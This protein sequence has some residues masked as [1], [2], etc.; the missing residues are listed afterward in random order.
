MLVPAITPVA[1]MAAPYLIALLSQ[2]PRPKGMTKKLLLRQ[3][4]RSVVSKLARRATIGI[5]IYG[6]YAA[7]RAVA[8][9]G[10]RA[11]DE[12]GRGHIKASA[13]YAGVTMANVVDVAAQSMVIGGLA[14]THLCGFAGCAPLLAHADKLSLTAAATSCLVGLYADV[15]SSEGHV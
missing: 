4:N 10:S 7:T 6:C 12:A 3:T 5:P 2:L 15:V 13:L 9:D 1:V 11:C 14:Y 8:R